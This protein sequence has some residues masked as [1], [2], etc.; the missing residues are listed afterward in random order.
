MRGF[1]ACA[2]AQYKRA[3]SQR[4]RQTDRPAGGQD[5]DIAVRNAASHRLEQVCCAL[6]GRLCLEG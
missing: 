4:L 3:N 2:A 5:G 6:E 1:R